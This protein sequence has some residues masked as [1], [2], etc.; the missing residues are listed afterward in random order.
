MVAQCQGGAAAQPAARA[1]HASCR[2]LLPRRPPSRRRP[3]LPP[4]RLLRRRAELVAKALGVLLALG[5]THMGLGHH[6]A[7]LPQ[8][9]ARGQAAWGGMSTGWDSGRLQGLPARTMQRHLQQRLCIACAAA[10]PCALRA[11]PLQASH[12]RQHLLCEPLALQPKRLRRLPHL[13]CAAHGCRGWRVGAMRA[14]HQQARRVQHM[15]MPCRC[16]EAATERAARQQ[17]AGHTS[18]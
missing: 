9:Q 13:C 1:E 15:R 18:A 17:A 8:L 6:I 12:L 2:E 16:M 11:T 14:L 3:L 7:R 5:S 4:L 10:S